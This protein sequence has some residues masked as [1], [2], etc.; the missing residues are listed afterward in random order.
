MDVGSIYNQIDIQSLL[1][2]GS[3]SVNRPNSNNVAVNQTADYAKK[4]EPMYIADM[5]SDED[6]T[7]T[8]DEFRDYC[9]SK[10][11]GTREVVKMSQMAAAYRTMKAEEGTIDY[12]SKL[13]PNVFPKL[14]QAGSE[15][16]GL[17]QG[18]EQYNISN[19]SNSPNL[20]PYQEYMEFCEKNADTNEQKSNTKVEFTDDNNLKILNFGK[21]SEAYRKNEE[22][23]LQSTFEE[24]V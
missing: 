6:G 9:K 12:I 20:V 7:I 19:D 5:D 3:N 13:I 11:M 8:L 2:N 24:V 16:G 23:F 18:E 1:T 21:T 15:S 10:G 4:G 22:S 14:K 17:K